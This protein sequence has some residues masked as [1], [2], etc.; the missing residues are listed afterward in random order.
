MKN[1]KK[2]ISYSFDRG[3]KFYESNAKIQRTICIELLNFYK[4]LVTHNHNV[5]FTNALEIG[6]GS[7][8]MTNQINKLENF[9]KIHLIDISKKMISIAKENFPNQNF[10]YEVKDFDNFKNYKIYDFIYS[11][12]SL[13]WSENFSKLFFYLLNQMPKGG[14]FIFSLL[15]SIKF[16]FDP[17]E[18]RKSLFEELINKFPDTDYSES[19]ID[20]EKFYFFSK[21][22]IF[23]EKFKKPIEFFLN[24]KSIGANVNFKKNKTNIFFLRRMNSEITINYDVIFFL[25]K[26]IRA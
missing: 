4:K 18:I 12:M 17:K 8:F 3:S 22:K 9:K 10:S 5:Q 19:Q 13:H 15:T 6:C 20:K 24:L 25:I 21:K 7:G 26:K 14:Y 11:N 1:F 2:K 16:D 23:K